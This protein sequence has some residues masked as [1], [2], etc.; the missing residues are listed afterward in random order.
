MFQIYSRLLLT[1]CRAWGRLRRFGRGNTQTNCHQMSKLQNCWKGMPT[2]PM[3][4]RDRLHTS[5]WWSLSLTGAILHNLIHDTCMNISQ[6][7]S[8]TS[9]KILSCIYGKLFVQSIS[10]TFGSAL[11]KIFQ[12][13]TIIVDD[14]QMLV[15]LMW[16]QLSPQS[17]RSVWPNFLPLIARILGSY[18]QVR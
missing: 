2:Q 18:R 16:M 4:R 15:S 6:I 8:G 5:F 11:N 14:M 13:V 1:C 17:M 12:G 10:H 3:R 7:W 9:L